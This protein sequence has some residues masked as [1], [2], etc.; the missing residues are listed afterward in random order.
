MTK[1]F[2]GNLPYNTTSEDLGKM[3]EPHGQVAEAT[4][5]TD[6]YSGKSRGFGFVE[7]PNDEEAQKAI[8]AL[9]G[10]EVE[11]RKLAVSVARPREDRPRGDFRRDRDR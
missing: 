1:L 4:V 3:F 10:N 8:E 7:M 9:N 5:I 6:R 2:V 11:D